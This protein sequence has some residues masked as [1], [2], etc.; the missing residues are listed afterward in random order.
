MASHPFG[1]AVVNNSPL[2]ILVAG[3]LAAAVL[4]PIR[5]QW[6]LGW[7]SYL[8]GVAAEPLILWGLSSNRKGPL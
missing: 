8:V 5:G 3:L 7:I 4:L 1:Q 2:L 6:L